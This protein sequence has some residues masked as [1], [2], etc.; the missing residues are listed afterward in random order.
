M[1]RLVLALGVAA[2]LAACSGTAT[3]P[4]VATLDDPVASGSPGASASPTASQDPRDAFLAYARC[5]REN[6]VDMPDPKFD[7]GGDGSIGFSVGGGT[8]PDKA[9]YEKADKACRQHL[10]KAISNMKPPELTPEEEEQLLQFA[11]CMREHGVD[12][13]DPGAGG[14][15][16][17]G[18]AAASGDKPD[19]DDKDFQ[20]AQ[21]AC[22]DLLPGR[23]GE[24]GRDGPL[25]IERGSGKDP[26]VEAPDGTVN[27]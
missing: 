19:V 15:I 1:I 25:T 17:G 13:P 27:Q 11:R 24:K 7:E 20:A 5:M 23:G 3:A 6:G 21:E 26:A 16:F 10:E 14:M 2:I 9:E 4:G 22:A 8:R 12:M 18:P